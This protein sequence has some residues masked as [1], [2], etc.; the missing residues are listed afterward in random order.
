LIGIQNVVV[1]SLGE[2]F[3]NLEG[4]SGATIMGDGRVGLILDANELYYEEK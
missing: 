4:V 1:K 2:K 3:K